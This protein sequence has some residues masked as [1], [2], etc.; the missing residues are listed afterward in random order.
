MDQMTDNQKPP[1]INEIKII[2][3]PNRK[4]T[5]SAKLTNGILFVSAPAGIPNEEL[6][7]IIS[8]FKESVAKRK[9]K[10][11]LNKRQDLKDIAG[12]LNR[13]YFS[14]CLKIESIEYSTNQ[15]SRFGC[16]N[17]KTG[18]ILISHRLAT[19]PEWVRNYVIVHELAHLIVP[20]H[21]KAFKELTNK[22]KLEERAI[23]FLM[24]KG[25]REDETDI[26][27]SFDNKH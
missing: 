10:K 27:D 25:Y 12:R 26:N 14:G 17:I 11:D 22:Y 2:R 9:L 1:L 23:G 19:M 3:S 6:Y 15:N 4:R 7:K 16:C 21:G 24:A 13:E 5:V 8:K 18:R 20:N